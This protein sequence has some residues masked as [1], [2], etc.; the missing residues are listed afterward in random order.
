MTKSRP[1]RPSQEQVVSQLLAAV[2]QKN[3][4]AT[5]ERTAKGML[6]SIPVRRPRWLV[7]PLSWV[8]PFSEKR[9]VELD[10]AGRL[11]LESCDGRR[12]VEEVI[13]RFAGEHKL[14][15]RESQL[16][17]TQFL[18]ELVKRGIIAI[19]GTNEEN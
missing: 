14:S 18:K 8:V 2:P 3:E 5:V 15:F 19:V 13:E 10:P 9:R 16:A 17:V 6:V 11:V 7:P 12:T 1:D 4:A